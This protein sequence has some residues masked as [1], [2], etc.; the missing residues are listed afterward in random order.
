MRMRRLLSFAFV[1]VMNTGSMQTGAAASQLA[2]VPCGFSGG[3]RFTAVAVDPH[4]P[5]IVLAGSDVAGVFRSIDGGDTFAPCGSGLTGF[6]IAALAFDPERAGEVYALADSGL[7]H[8]R[9]SGMHWCRISTVAA[10]RERF[11]GSSLLVFYNGS[12][13]AGT[14]IA[15][16]FRI[17]SHDSNPAVEPVAGLAGTRVSC[18]AVHS[19][20][21]L[22]ATSR[23]L[24]RFNGS[25][26][27]P[28]GSGLPAGSRDILD[29]ATHTSGRLYAVSKSSGL[30]RY[31]EKDMLWKQTTRAYASLIPGMPR[32]FKVLGVDPSDPDRV[33]MAAHPETWPFVLLESRN[34]GAGW[35]RSGRFA[36]PGPPLAWREAP[37]AIE[38]IYLCSRIPGRMFL[39]DWWNLWRSMDNGRSWQQLTHGLQ[40]SIVNDIRQHPADPDTLFMATADNGLVRS[41]NSGRTWERSMNGV[42]NG[43]AMAIAFSQPDGRA[44]YLLVD[45]WKKQDRIL[46]YTSIDNGSSWRDIGFSIEGL[47]LPDRI[48]AD[49]KPTGIIPAPGRNGIVY[50]G[51][52]GYGVFK[53]DDNGATWS[54]RNAGLDAPFLKNR[55]SLL[56]HPERPDT[57]FAATQDGGIYSTNDGARTWNKISPETHFAFGL[58]IDPFNPTHIVAACA[59]KTLL[60]SKD[61]GATWSKRV[62]PGDTPGHIAAHALVFDPAVRDRL[63][64]GTL[65]YD[66][67]AAD[68]LFISTD[69]GSTF[70]TAGID[71]PRISINV[72][73]VARGQ[74][75]RLLMG[76]NGIGMYCAD[77]RP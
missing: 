35:R 67:R 22:A 38:T 30:Y 18:L 27:L 56:A 2:A 57:L 10:F 46:V 52:N 58:A 62:L 71:L 31:D 32:A 36:A 54:A 20:T 37:E 19:G 74:R 47:Q 16:V 76:F 61:S 11:F 70:Q 4:K 39:A 53:T 5:M 59:G 44:L 43:H 68:G 77:I 34:A 75:P 3:G 13:W 9:D 15:G 29:L 65:A 45:P 48:Y 8:S 40:N 23:G 63:Y 7:Y 49:G 51:T 60:V 33:F 28:A 66:C 21:V 14:D 64:A 55:T 69:G 1:A 50:V 41:R 24:F 26:W 25:T 12:L 73:E 17:T 42:E 6:A 72:L